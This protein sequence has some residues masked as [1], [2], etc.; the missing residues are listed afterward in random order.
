MNQ[1]TSKPRTCTRNCLYRT[2]CCIV[3]NYTENA[4]YDQFLS[5]P[6]EFSDISIVPQSLY[7]LLQF[8]LKALCLLCS[9]EC[10]SSFDVLMTPSIP[11]PVPAQ[12]KAT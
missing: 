3:S 7:I 5:W 10:S 11:K 6:L 1:P 9:F 8:F 2:C 12:G 4:F